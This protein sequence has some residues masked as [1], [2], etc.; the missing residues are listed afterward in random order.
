MWTERR[1]L[2]FRRRLKATESLTTSWSLTW[3]RL[4]SRWPP[5]NSAK[6]ST[7]ASKRVGAIIPQ[8]GIVATTFQTAQYFQTV[9]KWRHWCQNFGWSHHVSSPHVCDFSIP[10]VSP[11]QLPKWRTLG[12][13]L[14]KSRNSSTKERKGEELFKNFLHGYDVQIV[15]TSW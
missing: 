6:S 15:T 14:K 9:D 11:L 8:R 5:K 7:N 1:P 12:E 4:L 13:E 2:N 10:S 3:T